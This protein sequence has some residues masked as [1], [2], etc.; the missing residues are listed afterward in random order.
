MSTTIG[1]RRRGYLGAGIALCGLA[2][3]S[4]GSGGAAM[5]KAPGARS[6][7]VRLMKIADTPISVGVDPRAH[8]VWV[9]A[10][11]HLIRISEVTHRITARI[12]M[13]HGATFVAIDPGLR[14][15]WTWDAQGGFADLSEVSEATNRVVHHIPGGWVWGMAVDP[16]TRSLWFLAN[17]PGHQGYSLVQVS[18][19]TRRVRHVIR[20]PVGAN[21]QV[22]SVAVDAATGTVWVTATPTSAPGPSWLAEISEST[23]LITHVIPFVGRNWEAPLA[24]DSATGTI[25]IATV[26][27][28]RVA[29]ISAHQITREFIAP[30]TAVA[31]AIASRAR[32]V[33]ADRLNGRH[34]NGGLALISETTGMV[35]GTVLE[36]VLAGDVAVDQWTGEAFACAIVRGQGV[37][38]EFRA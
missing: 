15:V 22:A 25:W 2:A 34:G 4:L 16:R 8:A 11:R 20:L 19:Q 7:Q 37:I 29:R 26:S 21:Q 9:T 3:A 36:N 1:A 28:L 38:A 13:S 23:H 27:R 18:E 33:V 5:A 24:A 17:Y 12:A 32:T 35:T 6:I 31:L 10:R 14:V 30:V